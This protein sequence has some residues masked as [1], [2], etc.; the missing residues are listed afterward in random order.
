MSLTPDIKYY[1]NKTRSPSLTR[2]QL[3]TVKEKTL[4][5]LENVGVKVPNKKAL[6][7][8]QDQGAKIVAGLKIC[9]SRS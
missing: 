2:E 1:T 7:I 3:L 9:V 6:K 8:Y 5:L 4:Y